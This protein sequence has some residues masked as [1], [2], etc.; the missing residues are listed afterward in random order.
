MAAQIKGKHQVCPCV[1]CMVHASIPAG[2]DCASNRYPR[3]AELTMTKFPG[4]TSF[5]VT[6]SEVFVAPKKYSPF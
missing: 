5:L 6:L 2:A 1:R 3:G 4:V